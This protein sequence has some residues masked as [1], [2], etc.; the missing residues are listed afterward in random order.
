[1]S[2]RELN[3]RF[4][5]RY[6]VFTKILR[7]HPIIDV[8]PLFTLGSEDDERN[9]KALPYVIDWFD[10]AIIA[11]SDEDS[12]SSVSSG[13]ISE[14]DNEKER[15]DEYHI[16]ERKLSAIYQ[17]ALTMPL[18][19]VPSMPDMLLLHKETRDQLKEENIKLER[20]IARLL[21]TKKEVE[22]RI[23]VKD[24]T[25]ENLQELLDSVKMDDKK[26]KRS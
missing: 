25:V 15:Y 10:K 24:K 1:M 14:S 11:V 4:D 5:K 23:K 13:D 19:F 7:Y 26:R 12:E 22:D 3:S 18:Q 6:V 8:E 21:Q 2:L 9:L 16:E 17:F 20:Q